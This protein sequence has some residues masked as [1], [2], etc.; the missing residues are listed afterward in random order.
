MPSGIRGHIPHTCNSAGG[1]SKWAV[2]VLLGNNIEG[3]CSL[4][5]S[6]SYPD[7]LSGLYQTVQFKRRS[8]SPPE[9]K[10]FFLH[11]VLTPPFTNTYFWG[12]K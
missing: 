6:L 2:S 12:I 11:V 5:L 10:N 1:C 9:K 7:V 3:L 8:V 4:L